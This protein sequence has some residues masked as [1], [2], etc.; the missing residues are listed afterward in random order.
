MDN[1]TR[2]DRIEMIGVVLNNNT[3]LFQ[4]ELETPDKQVIT[5]KPSGKIRQ[6]HINV[7]AGD[8]VKVELSPYDLTKG[9]IMRRL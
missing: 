1:E 6:N 4:V 2:D 3:G 7:V 9:R 5:C 8:R